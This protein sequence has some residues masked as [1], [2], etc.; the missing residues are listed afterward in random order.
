MVP[1][2]PRW[3][4]R[5]CDVAG[6]A[7][8]SEFYIYSLVTKL[9]AC[10]PWQTRRWKRSIRASTPL[11]SV[12]NI[13][14]NFPSCW[15]RKWNTFTKISSKN[16]CPSEKEMTP[17]INLCSSR[18]GN[19]PLRSISPPPGTLL[20]HCT[21]VVCIIHPVSYRWHGHKFSHLPKSHSW[22]VLKHRF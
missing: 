1:A 19:Q 8:W 3:R 14:I 22:Y 5:T 11:P 15:K 10:G 4:P 6:E 20:S 2:S 7:S 21:C 9:A 12:F 17:L 13:A 18:E 16:P